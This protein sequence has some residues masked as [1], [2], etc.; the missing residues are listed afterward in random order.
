MIMLFLLIL[1]VKAL[2]FVD[3]VK[4]LI[5]KVDILLVVSYLSSKC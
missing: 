1:D 4:K 2:L 5:N 3:F